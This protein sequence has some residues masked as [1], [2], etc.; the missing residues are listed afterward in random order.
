MKK[1]PIKRCR[2][3][4]WIKIW[5][6]IVVADKGIIGHA[7]DLFPETSRIIQLA[8]NYHLVFMVT[9]IIN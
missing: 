5:T 7:N 6:L 8:H 2:N 9:M 4:N 1:L 3:C